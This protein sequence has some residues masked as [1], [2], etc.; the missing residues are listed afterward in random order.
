M[1]PQNALSKPV[2][3]L[4]TV[5]MLACGASRSNSAIAA[6][7]DKGVELSRESLD[8]TADPGTDRQ[9]IPQ[10]LA[11]YDDQWDAVVA[12]LQQ[13]E[14]PEVR[15]GPHFF[16]VLRLPRRHDWGLIYPIRVEIHVGR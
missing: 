1:A 4:I 11:R 15:L 16:R 7:L 14:F 12:Q 13:R 3:I 9:R 5:V 8:A 6:D 10:R 2:T